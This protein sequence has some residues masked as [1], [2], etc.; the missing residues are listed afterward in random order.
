MYKFET[1]YKILNTELYGANFPFESEGEG[2]GK[3]KGRSYEGVA[4]EER[5]A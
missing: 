3:G 2:K 1:A 5:K 4:S